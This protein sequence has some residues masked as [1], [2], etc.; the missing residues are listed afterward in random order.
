[1]AFI[2]AEIA[3]P[4][5]ETTA[6]PIP[7]RTGEPTPEPTAEII[8]EPT[9]LCTV[10]P[11]SEPLVLNGD[12]ETGDT[13]GWIGDF[14]IAPASANTGIYGARMK[15]SSTMTQLITGL[16]PNTDYILSYYTKFAN[17]P[18]TGSIVL[19]DYCNVI[20]EKQFVNDN[21]EWNYNTIL[22]TLSNGR[23]NLSITFYC[24]LVNVNIDDVVLQVR[25]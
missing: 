13:T 5:P 25:D 22:F 6:D 10:E 24:A 2:T 21:A 17:V 16:V 3:E 23:T 19:Q 4:T 8:G 11:T 12:F 14:V 7:E 1:L 18:G 9:P 20:T 15:I